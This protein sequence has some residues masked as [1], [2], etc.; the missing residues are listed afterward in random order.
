MHLAAF[1]P[2][3]ELA[4]L[5]SLQAWLSAHSKRQSTASIFSS[6]HAIGDMVAGVAIGHLQIGRIGLRGAFDGADAHVPI[7]VGVTIG[8]ILEAS[9]SNFTAAMPATAR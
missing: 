3:G 8:K 5:A 1:V 2:T 4:F 6:L 9:S 7:V